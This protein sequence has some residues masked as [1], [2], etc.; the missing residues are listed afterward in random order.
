MTRRSLTRVAA[1]IV[2]TVA[3]RPA[4]PR[5][6]GGV[7]PHVDRTP[8][9]C[10]RPTRLRIIA[11]NDFHGA[12]EPRPDSIGVVRGGAAV[13]ASMIATARA[14][15]LPSS[16]V[17]ILLDAGDTFQGTPASNLAFG[18]PVTDVYNTLDYA[19]SALGNHEFDWGQDTLR[20]MMRRSRYEF[21]GANVRYTDGRDVEWIPDDT[22]VA[23]GSVRVGVIGIITTSTPQETRPSTIAGLRFDD[24]API[25][26]S[27]ARQ[28]RSRGAD[29]V[30]VVAHAGAYCRPTCTGE[31]ITFAKRLT[32]KVDAIVSGHTHSLVDTEVNGIPIVQARSSGAAIAVVDVPLLAGAGP[33]THQ[34]RDVITGSVTPDPRVA[35]IVA[36]ATRAVAARTEH[37]EA[38]LTT[39]LSQHQTGE[40]IA[41]AVRSITHADV[42]FVNSSGVRTDLPAGPVTYGRLFE[43]QP[44]GNGLFK[45]AVRGRDLREYLERRV[46]GTAQD[47]QMSGATVVYDPR[48]PVGSRITE[49][50]LA[51]GSWLSD[52]QEYTVALNDYMVTNASFGFGAAA[53]RTQDLHMVDLDALVMYLHNLPQ[54]IA[55]PAGQRFVSR[56]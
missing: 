29:A 46:H 11:T 3:C 16:C 18:R 9:C 48:R 4:T 32:A 25:V 51:D 21:L 15:C 24:A 33:A 41:D 20:A 23:L 42:A 56:P 53:V 13:V 54:P 39:A 28:L 30:V 31:I 40:L 27:L 52:D 19:A 44:F 8:E 55:P 37:V 12:L 50:R 43:V 7:Q 26:D 38:T 45:I 47:A 34:I 2:A 1:V 36:R 14:E 17:P 22:L 49:V 6:S 35:P 10:V 5:P